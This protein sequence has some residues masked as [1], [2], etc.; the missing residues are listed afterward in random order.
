MPRTPGHA[1]LL[2]AVALLLAA[3]LPA[4]AQPFRTDPMVRIAARLQPGT[5]VRL[6]APGLVVEN[7]RI[8]RTTPDSLLVREASTSVGV[9]LG[10]IVRLSVQ[11]DRAVQGAL[12]GAG[13]AFFVGAAAGAID[14]YGECGPRA[15]CAGTAV[16]RALLVGGV[17]AVP[18]GLAG[19]VLGRRARE[20]QQV[21]P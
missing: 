7:G 16:G 2:L 5:A 14:G 15:S 6:E 1:P 17:A 3:P 19:W 13:M 8:V 11:R 10:E 20:W 4:S 18:G 12:M 21:V 9:A